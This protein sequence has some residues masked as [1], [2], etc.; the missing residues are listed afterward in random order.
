MTNSAG[1]R[2]RL[3]IVAP[4]GI[5]LRDLLLN[6]DLSAY[7]TSRFDLDVMSPF[8]FQNEKAWG[9]DRSL[10]M[11]PKSY[12]G[13][14][15]Q[16]V[17]HR[18]F[19]TRYRMALKRFFESTGWDA[20]Y[21]VR[22]LVESR[23]DTAGPRFDR[24]ERV[25]S[26]PFGPVLRGLLSPFPVFYPNASALRRERYAAV[27]V[28]H[29]TDGECTIMAT[30]A[31]RRGIPVVCL[32]MGSDNL[33]TG[34][35]MMMDPD[36]LLLWGPEQVSELEDHHARFRPTLKSTQAREIGSLSHDHLFRER[37]TE[38]FK[39]SYPEIADDATV[40]TFAGYTERGDPGQKITCRL[41]LRFFED[42]GIDGH[43]IIRVRPLR[44][45]VHI[46]S[47]F[48]RDHPGKVTVQVPKGDLYTKW[49]R[50]SDPVIREVEEKDIAL[51]A[52]TLH[53]SELLVMGA[54][55]TVFLDAHATGTPAIA[56]GIHSREQPDAFLEQ[57]YKL[58]SK[59]IPSIA[60]LDL[61]VDE[62]ELSKRLVEALLDS[63]PGRFGEQS[64]KVYAAQAGTL[65][66]GAG[67]RAVA[68]IEE[69]LTNHMR[70]PD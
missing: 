14:I 1:G 49:T 46:W 2:D 60:A 70:R 44:N 47:D 28:T 50:G 16:A 7:L 48:A 31:R 36:L 19:S 59:S 10:P 45:E 12:L 30:A 55:S 27:F 40:V 38:A 63:A 6:E 3:L 17:N 42:H 23:G 26:S 24:W 39:I 61:V 35:P 67:K 33:S 54:F 11:S 9:I 56:V 5:A 66:G 68:A 53:R 62:S 32:S 37:S 25:A 8:Q 29:P 15:A 58:H 64:R 4:Y 43:L 57:I 69:L 51:F 18:A 34:G 21:Q 52:S 65:D 20:G 13:H 22:T 41:I